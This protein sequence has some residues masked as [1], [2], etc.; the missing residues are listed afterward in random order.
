MSLNSAEIS[1]SDVSLEATSILNNLGQDLSTPQRGE[2]RLMSLNSAEIASS[3]A[4]LEDLL[5]RLRKA[6]LRRRELLNY[7][8]VANHMAVVDHGASHEVAIAEETSG[9]GS[10]RIEKTYQS[11]VRYRLPMEGVSTSHARC[12]YCFQSIYISDP[13]LA[14]R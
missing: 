4:S 8:R 13:P 12:Y 9:S 11:A 1:S 7:W 3:D 5:E 6:S 2:R 10:S 14:W